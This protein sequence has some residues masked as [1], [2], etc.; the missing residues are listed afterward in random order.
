MADE[1]L[2]KLSEDKSLRDT[3]A[4]GTEL[5]V[6][7]VVPGDARDVE[8]PERI[9][10]YRLQE[11][12]GRGGMAL[13]IRVYDEL[14]DRSLALKITREDKT[15]DAR[16]RASLR[17][18][19]EREAQLTGQMQHPGI[20]PVTEKGHLEDGRPF[21]I[22]KLVKGR[23]LQELLQARGAD[24]K[25]V[26]R[27][28]SIFRSVC[29]TLAYA[30]SR[31]ILH[32]DLKPSNIMV[33]AFGE[34]QV[35]DWGLAKVMP[36]P[37]E[38][39][40]SP[41]EEE[42]RT[43]FSPFPLR[44]AGTKGTPAFIPPE[45]ARGEELDTRCDVFGLGGILC[46]I[47]TGKPPF[48]TGSTEEVLHRAMKGDLAEAFARL[49]GCAGDVELVK[50]AK[51]CL[52]PEKADRLAEL[53]LPLFE[54]AAEKSKTKLGPDHP[55][56]LTLMSD[57]AVTYQMAGKVERALPLYKLAL[58]KRKLKLGPDHPD[59]LI[60]MNNLA[61]GYSASGKLD[62]AIP[63]Y[64]ET[65]AKM[66]AKLGPDHAE[67]L[68]TLSNLAQ[69]QGRAKNLA[70]AETLKKYS[71][72]EPLLLA[73]GFEEASLGGGRKLYDATEQPAQAKKWRRRL[74]DEKRGSTSP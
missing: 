18:R 35:M 5:Q 61:W 3:A 32:R 33:G 73:G 45:Q 74:A 54:E 65:L 6:S 71:E 20:P 67:T 46:V 28:L 49:D 41:A 48:A 34:V 40:Q 36:A 57:L 13:V 10:R 70:A 9:R 15:L 26:P 24:D 31:R 60:G 63:L 62:L 30:H 51:H 12:V 39:A 55:E 17:E 59:T 25:E 19:F 23:T 43:I 56:T 29:E 52:A 21:F 22:M 44:S 4:S 68:N 66:K 14:F 72:A 1:L 58:E 53:A 50:L 8:L 64:E 47:L 2:P 16:S 11:E 69:A 42:T 27:F 37:G 38:Q 7:E